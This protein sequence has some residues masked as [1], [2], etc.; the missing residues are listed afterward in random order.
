MAQ[1]LFPNLKPGEGPGF[2]LVGLE[3]ADKSFGRG[4]ISSESNEENKQVLTAET[5]GSTL[6]LL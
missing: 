1:L 6:L 4:N 5:I 2:L 3:M